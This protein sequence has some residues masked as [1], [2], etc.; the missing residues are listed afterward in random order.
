MGISYGLAVHRKWATARVQK[1]HPQRSAESR[2]R[3]RGSRDGADEMK[4]DD[5]LERISD[6]ADNHKLIYQLE[7]VSKDK[8]SARF[9]FLLVPPDN[10][11]NYHIAKLVNDIDWLKDLVEE[12]VLTTLSHNGEKWEFTS[13]YRIQNVHYTDDGGLE[14]Y[15]RFKIHKILDPTFLTPYEAEAERKSAQEAYEAQLYGQAQAAKKKYETKLTKFQRQ[16]ITAITTL[17]EQ[18]KKPTDR[19]TQ[20]WLNFE[21]IKH[22]YN[23]EQRQYCLDHIGRV[24]RKLKKSGHID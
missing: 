13:A 4:L 23:H 20:M 8:L 24:R 2:Q 5:I 11:I 6:I 18:G 21:G 7:Y 17:R 22:Q 16:L 19:E 10:S 15:I 3:P 14:P 1:K 9:A 12:E